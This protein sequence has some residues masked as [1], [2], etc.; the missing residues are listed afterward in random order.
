MKTRLNKFVSFI[1]IP[2]SLAI[3]AMFSLEAIL[4]VSSGLV[5]GAHLLMYGFFGII[6]GIIVATFATRKLSN[7]NLALLNLLC[8]IGINAF[9]YWVY[10]KEMKESN[11]S[12]EIKKE[13]QVNK[14]PVSTGGIPDPDVQMEVK[15]SKSIGIGMSK[16]VLN[17][18]NTIE[19]LNNPGGK[20]KGKI[21]F[22]M[23]A[24][25]LEYE[26]KPNAF[27][28]EFNK[29]D[30]NILYF[31]TIAQEGQFLEIITNKN[32]NKSMWATK[33]DLRF[34]PWSEFF[35]MVHSVEPIDP[36]SNPLRS[37]PDAGSPIINNYSEDQILKAV[38]VQ[39]NW[40]K[41]DIYN[42]NYEVIGNGWFQWRDDERLLI[43]YNLLS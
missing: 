3:V 15:L 43:S 28:P 34:L 39:S 20:V 42:Q 5:S 33:E 8:F 17:V 19:L 22:K 11:T 37:K 23:G 4:G 29:L 21:S 14:T 10:Q 12:A 24:T 41:V 35:F 31:K 32:T 18:N 38:I 6:V 26:Q 1:L 7:K 16:A 40:I 36:V 25:G 27:N 13:I 9:I 30:Y 2:I